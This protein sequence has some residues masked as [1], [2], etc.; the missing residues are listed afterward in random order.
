MPFTRHQVTN[1]AVGC[2]H[3]VALAV[4]R[5]DVSMPLFYFNIQDGNSLSSDSEGTE[6]TGAHEA[7][8]DAVRM[9][10]A[11]ARDEWHDGRGT[12]LVVQVRDEN[13]RPVM[14]AKIDCAVT[15]FDTVAKRNA[16]ASR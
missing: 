13:H 6:Y 3:F 7:Q 15:I 12:N 9:L 16:S 8:V 1:C 11:I 5:L 2:L 4:S 14:E 10:V